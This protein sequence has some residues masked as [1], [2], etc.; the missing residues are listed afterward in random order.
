MK[1]RRSRSPA[2]L[3]PGHGET[4][5]ENGGT[6]PRNSEAPGRSWRR[7]RP[8]IRASARSS[9]PGAGRP[10]GTA[11]V[12]THATFFAKRTSSSSGSGQW[13]KR[14]FQGGEATI[15]SPLSQVSRNAG[16]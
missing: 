13:R 1:V 16:P 4:A 10:L 11:G 14:S 2:A 9:S 3:A 6:K 12:S 15:R 5:G 7:Q 8:P